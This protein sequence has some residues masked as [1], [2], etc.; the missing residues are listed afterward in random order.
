MLC[1]QAANVNQEHHLLLYVAGLSVIDM[2]GA[3]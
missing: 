1:L 3:H 2:S